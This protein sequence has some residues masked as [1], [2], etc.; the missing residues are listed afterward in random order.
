MNATLNRND[1]PSVP[2]LAGW[3][4]R[5]TIELNGTLIRPLS[6]KE[7]GQLKMLKKGLGSWT[8]FVL[9]WVWD[10]WWG[11]CE[12][13]KAASGIDSAPLKPHIGFALRHY[14]VAV[15]LM[16]KT[17]KTK[18]AITPEDICFKNSVS[19]MMSDLHKKFEEHLKMLEQ[20]GV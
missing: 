8:F 19:N 5:R 15:N 7:L 16:D 1:G 2:A 12:E 20:M 4:Q 6:P 18:V 10:N 11:F 9:N 3:W 14:D 13:A 17:A